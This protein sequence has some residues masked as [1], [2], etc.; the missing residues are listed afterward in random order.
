M[1]SPILRHITYV[2]YAKFLG[3]EN[4]MNI[5]RDVGAH[6]GTHRADGSDMGKFLTPSLRELTHTAPYMHNGMLATLTDVVD[7]YDAGGGDDP[8]KSRDLEPL[9]LARTEKEDL[10]AFL[11]ALSGEPLMGPAFVWEGDIPFDYPAIA[12][13]RESRN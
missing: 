2:T 3:V 12:N 7:F 1:S 13:W 9:N 8:N 6:V 10:V 4:Y 11:D 5:R